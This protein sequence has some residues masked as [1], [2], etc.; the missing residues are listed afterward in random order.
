MASSLTRLPFDACGRWS[1]C[2]D[3]DT[4][5]GALVG[6]T[7]PTIC[8]DA[9]FRRDRSG[10]SEIVIATHEGLRYAMGPCEESL[11]TMFPPAVECPP[12]AQVSP[13]QGGP[14][15]RGSSD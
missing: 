15:G 11:Q 2:V 10:R 9:R 4:T 8:T 14:V 5:T 7:D 6:A 1:A 13:C 12:T 3:I